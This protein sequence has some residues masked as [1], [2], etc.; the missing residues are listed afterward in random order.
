MYFEHNELQSVLA[1]LVLIALSGMF[2]IALVGSGLYQ[3]GMLVAKSGM[4]ALLSFGKLMI[5]YALTMGYE[6]LWSSL[7]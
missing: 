3:L 7:Y 4:H 2:G 6:L 5:R 1:P